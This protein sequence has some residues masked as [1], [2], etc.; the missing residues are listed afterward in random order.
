MSAVT[1]LAAGAKADSGSGSAVD[2][3]GCASLKL[4]LTMKADA[5]LNPNLTVAIDT[6]PG[7]AGPWTEIYNQRFRV[8]AGGGNTWPANSI[9]RAVVAPD[10]FCRAR[11]SVAHSG[12]T[13]AAL[14]LSIVGVGI[15]D[16]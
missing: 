5:S 8:S 1:L 2:C 4:A 7:S 10:V 16:A 12:T 6:A 9:A 13:T 15:P 3:T 14:D 11:W